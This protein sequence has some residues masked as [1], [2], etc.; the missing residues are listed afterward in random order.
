MRVALVMPRKPR[1]KLLEVGID[2]IDKNFSKLSTVAVRLDGLD[3]DRLAEHE[4]S[5]VLARDLAVRL[6]LF[7][8]IDAG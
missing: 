7:G 1:A 6:G 2:P 8:G 4:S 3:R 5:E